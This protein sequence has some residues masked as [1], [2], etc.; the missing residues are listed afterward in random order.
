MAVVEPGLMMKIGKD[1]H[2]LEDIVEFLLSI[3]VAVAS[4]IY[5]SEIMH[6]GKNIK[7]PSWMAH[8]GAA[9]E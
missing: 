1:T 6:M 5:D 2:I 8:S 9:K 4:I 3:S 7:Q